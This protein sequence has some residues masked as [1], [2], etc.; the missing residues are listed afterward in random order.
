[1]VST[2]RQSNPLSSSVLTLNQIKQLAIL[3]VTRLRLIVEG[4]IPTPL[5]SLI[6]NP[7]SKLSL[8]LLFSITLIRY[9]ATTLQLGLALG[10]PYLGQWRLKS[11]TTIVLQFGPLILLKALFS[12]RRIQPLGSPSNLLYGGRG[13]RLQMLN[14][15]IVYY[16]SSPQF[17]INTITRFYPQSV[18]QRHL[19]KILLLIKRHTLVP[20]QGGQ[21]RQNLLLIR[22]VVVG[23]SRSGLLLHHTSCMASIS[24]YHIYLFQRS[25]YIYRQLFPILYYSTLIV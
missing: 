13:F 25:S 21:Y 15:V 20:K 4:F 10:P 2:G 14:T 6:I 18:I 22:L 1:M 19:I 3:G 8:S 11:P 9:S 12:F 5:A 23:R 17:V 7:I 24:Y 16:Q